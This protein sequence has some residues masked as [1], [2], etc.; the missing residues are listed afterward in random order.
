MTKY[1][2]EKCLREFSQKSHYDKHKNKKR[3]CQDNKSKIQEVVEQLIDEK[4]QKKLNNDNTDTIKLSKMTSNQKKKPTIVETFVG[5]GGAHI[6]F[7]NKGFESL[8]V[9]D[10]DKNMTATLIKNKCVNTDRIVTCPIEDLTD[11]VLDSKINK[12]V[13]VLFGGIVCKGFSLAGV[14]NPFDNRNYLYKHQLRLVDKL[15]PKISIIENV[16]GFKNMK[17]YRKNEETINTFNSYSTLSDINKKLNGE[18]SSRRKSNQSY[19]D[20]QEQIK[21]NK[22][23]MENLLINIKRYEYSIFDE[24]KLEYERMGY[25]VYN[26][27]LKANLY[28]GYTH[29]K[30][31]IIVAVKNNIEKEYLFPDEKK[32]YTLLDALNKIDVNGINNPKIDIDNQ[33]MKHNEKTIRRFKFIPEG[34]NIANIIDLLPEDLKVSKFYS[35]GNTQRLDRNESVPT[36]VPGHSNFPIHPVEDR[37]ITVR[38][39]ATITGFPLDYKFVG[40]HSARCMQVGNAVPVYLAEAIAESVL[41]LL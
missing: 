33:P 26:K 9:N 8:L 12:E 6:G 1:T 29:R 2:C 35:R 11:E 27:V 38:E 20:I 31:L 25:K 34:K 22:K 17:L 23:E 32:S 13:D 10:I 24:I 5:C 39:A 15:K 28:N 21:S 7:K 18:K 36:L 41:R 19:D 3:P 37:S 14:R 16:V 40:N 30:R 4:L